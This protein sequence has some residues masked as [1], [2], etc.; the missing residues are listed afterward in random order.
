MRLVRLSASERMFLKFRLL[1]GFITS[2]VFYF[3]CVVSLSGFPFFLLVF[4]KPCLIL[5][6]IEEETI[7][8]LR[9]FSSQLQMKFPKKNMV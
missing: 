4:G 5:R 6:L 3:V 1:G 7:D 9:F 8:Q 2:V